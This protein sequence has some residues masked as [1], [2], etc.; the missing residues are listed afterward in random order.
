MELIGL[1]HPLAQELLDRYKRVPAEAIGVA[2][3]ADDA[4]AGV[5]SLWFV[6]SHGKAGERKGN[7]QA[8]AAGLDGQRLPQM[9]RAV[10][11][12]FH[13]VP[14]EPSLTLDKRLAILKRNLEPSAFSRSPAPWG[15]R[16]WDG[17]LVRA[18]WLDWMLTR[19]SPR[20]P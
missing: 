11:K 16:G 10:E 1:D 18:H 7:V 5:V 13:H 6:E 20:R 8:M 3:K 4:T 17:I 14:A 2:V 12:V 9:E 19:P 15:G